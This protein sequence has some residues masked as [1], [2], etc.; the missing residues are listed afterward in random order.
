MTFATKKQSKEEQFGES[1]ILRR[2]VR[3]FVFLFPTKY[4]RQKCWCLHDDFCYIKKVSKG[5][6]G[7]F[8]LAFCREFCLAFCR[9][10]CLA[11]SNGRWNVRRLLGRR[12]SKIIPSTIS[13]DFLKSVCHLV[14]RSRIDLE[15]LWDLPG[16]VLD[17]CH[18]QEHQPWICCFVIVFHSA[19]YYT[20]LLITSAFSCQPIRPSIQQLSEKEHRVG[21]QNRPLGI[22]GCCYHGTPF[23]G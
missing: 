19:V 8:V 22:Q 18:C 6:I 3:Q 4:F 16:P 12:K 10:F 7:A 21:R 13:V 11:F 15:V 1:Q 5:N 17:N 14:G 23:Q 9:A 20:C 2:N